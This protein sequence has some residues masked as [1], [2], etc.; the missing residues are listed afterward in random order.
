MFESVSVDV[1]GR[2]LAVIFSDLSSETGHHRQKYQGTTVFW[3]SESLSL[4]V[5]D[6]FLFS[7]FK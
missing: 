7:G 6:S 5:S 1:H 3:E 2:L 4:C